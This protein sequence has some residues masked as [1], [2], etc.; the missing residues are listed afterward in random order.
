MRTPWGEIAVSDAH[1][2]FFSRKFF[3]LLA[4]QKPGLTAESAVTA[5]GWQMPP[6]DPAALAGLWVEEMDRHG[7]ARAALIASLPGD[8]TS[9]ESAVERFPD[10]FRGYAMVNPCAEGTPARVEKMLGGGGIRCLCFFPAMHGYSMADARARALIEIASA[11]S[12]SV[13]FVHCGVLSVGIRQKLGLPSKFDLRFSNPIDLHSVA[14]AF[15][16]VPFVVPHFGAGYFR[17][18]LMLCDL[19]SNVSL[20]T[21]SSNRWMMYEGLDLKSVFQRALEVT[22]TKRLIFGTD[23]SFFPRGWQARIFEEQAAALAALQIERSAA[24][25]IFYGNFE[26][27][28]PN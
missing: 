8:E 5:V 15:P 20:D 10:R 25:A 14:L 16:A 28:F 24:E 23:S 22:G 27:L 2:H 26:N 13:V 1:V 19:C 18:A 4:A 9:V 17:E 6:E 12:G 11:A 21:S 7:V 3:S